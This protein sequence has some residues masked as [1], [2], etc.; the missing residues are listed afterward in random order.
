MNLNIAQKPQ[1]ES[2]EKIKIC[3]SPFAYRVTVSWSHTHIHTKKNILGSKVNSGS[4][5]TKNQETE[6]TITTVCSL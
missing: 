1:A 6:K 2:T 3:V 5:E 4:M